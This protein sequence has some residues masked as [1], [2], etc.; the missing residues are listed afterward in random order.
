MYVRCKTFKMY[1][2]KASE[3]VDMK[4]TKIATQKKLKLK[5]SLITLQKHFEV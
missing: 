5:P 2:V 1:L 3:Q 4:M